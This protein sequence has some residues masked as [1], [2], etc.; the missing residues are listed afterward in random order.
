VDA[1]YSGSWSSTYSLPKAKVVVV[2]VD[3]FIVV[4]AFIIFVGVAMVAAVTI[5]VVA[6]IIVVDAAVFIAD[7]CSDSIQPKR[8]LNNVVHHPHAPSMAF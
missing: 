3:D 5:V 2:D 8:A 7:P 6:V 4:V 1:S